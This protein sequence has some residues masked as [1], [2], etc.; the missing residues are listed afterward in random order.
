MR[1]PDDV[2]PG[3]WRL[4]FLLPRA[5]CRVAAGRLQQLTEHGCDV[6]MSAA[7]HIVVLAPSRNRAFDQATR[8]ICARGGNEPPGSIS[9]ILTS[10]DGASDGW[11]I[12]VGADVAF[13]PTGLGA[14]LPALTD[15]L[16]P[17]LVKG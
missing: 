9:A 16:L 4:C 5:I 10:P 13:A 1:A 2:P 11:T 15:E 14:Y 12:I 3:F 6:D 17:L 7:P 8:L